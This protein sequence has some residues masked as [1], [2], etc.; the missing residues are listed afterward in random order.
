MEELGADAKEAAPALEKIMLDAKSLDNLQAAK[1]LWRINQHP[2]V[3]PTLIAILKS[4]NPIRRAIAVRALGDIGR[5]AKEAT[6][7]LR[8]LLRDPSAEVREA[9]ATALRRIEKK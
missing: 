5:D 2:K 3:V 4:E 9:A 8:G 1:T 7:E 6:P